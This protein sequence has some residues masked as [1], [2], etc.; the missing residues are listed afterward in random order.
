MDEIWKD[1]QGYEGYYQASNLGRV[2]SLNRIKCNG[3]KLS[4]KILKPSA[5]KDGYLHV[6]LSADKVNTSYQVHRLIASAFI[7]NKERKPEVNHLDEIKTNNTPENLCW[8]TRKENMNHGTNIERTSHKN[9]KSVIQLTLGMKPLK[10]WDSISDV[11]NNLGYG[12]GYI[13][14]CCNKKCESAYGYIWRFASEITN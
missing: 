1:I 11:S 14:N 10:V 3:H 8:C 9:R 7:E 4:G 6:V 12:Q 13:S 5:D 2:R